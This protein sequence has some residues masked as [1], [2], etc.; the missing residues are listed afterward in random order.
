MTIFKNKSCKQTKIELHI[1][2]VEMISLGVL[3]KCNFSDKSKWAENMCTAYWSLFPSESSYDESRLK[4]C[5]PLWIIEFHTRTSGWHLSH[6]VTELLL[7]H[8]GIAQSS[9]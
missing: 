9:K 8:R 7:V 5:G 4:H 3:G 6:S 1:I 2:D